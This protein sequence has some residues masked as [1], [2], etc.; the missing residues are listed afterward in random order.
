MHNSHTNC[1]PVDYYKDLTEE[2]REDFAVYV[3]VSVN[4]QID[5]CLNTGC[6]CLT[7]KGQHKQWIGECEGEMRRGRKKITCTCLVD[8]HFEAGTLG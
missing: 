1:V 5:Q 2:I 8:A 6:A 3:A 4:R 7:D